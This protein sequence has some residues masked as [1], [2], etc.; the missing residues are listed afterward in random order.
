MKED[1]L[2]FCMKD[3][4]IK[5]NQGK[6][7]TPSI[8]QYFGSAV[9]IL[10]LSDYPDNMLDMYGNIAVVH[11]YQTNVLPPTM[12]PTLSSIVWPTSCSSRQRRC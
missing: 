6:A 2:F 11:R 7:C 9:K 1:M 8:S 5:N 10:V 12:I 4:I 3:M